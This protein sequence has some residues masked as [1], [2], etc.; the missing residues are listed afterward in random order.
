MAW[1]KKV[2]RQFK[3]K[4]ILI[5]QDLGLNPSYLMSAMAFETGESFRPDIRNA[6]G[7]GATG[8]I[9]FMPSTA[10]N[11][12][13]TTAQLAHMTD[14]EQLDYVKKYFLPKQGKLHTLEDVYCMIF[15]PKAIGTQNDYIIARK[16]KINNSGVEVDDPI[17]WQNAG[18]DTG[19]VGY[20]T[21]YQIS[22]KLREKYRKGMSD[23]YIG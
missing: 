3:Q 15:Y 11:L 16:K 17:Y 23:G 18:F 19:N 14:V 12:G 13:T 5:S 8:L 20:I 4:V 21:K 2:S 1:G 9:Q 7:S 6:A 10:A 22:S